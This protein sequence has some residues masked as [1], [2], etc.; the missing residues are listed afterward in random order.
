MLQATIIQK[1]TWHNTVLIVMLQDEM[2]IFPFV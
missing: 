2:S 1:P